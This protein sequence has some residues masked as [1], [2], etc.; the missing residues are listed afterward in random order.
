MKCTKI[1]LPFCSQAEKGYNDK[2]KKACKLSMFRVS[3][4]TA[5]STTNWP[6][7][8]E[9]FL[10]G[11]ALGAEQ[12]CVG[13]KITVSGSGNDKHPREKCPMVCVCLVVTNVK[14][15]SHSL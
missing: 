15:L 1:S 2:P 10:G 12:C 5:Y 8:F 6:F 13:S 7:S 11:P 14:F 9:V 4:I 3:E